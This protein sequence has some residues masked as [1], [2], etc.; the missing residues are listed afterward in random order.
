[1]SGV[2]KASELSIRTKISVQSKPEQ[3]QQKAK[4]SDTKSSEDSVVSDI[5]GKLSDT[6]VSGFVSKL[7][8]KIASEP[9]KAVAA[10]ANQQEERVEQ[11]TA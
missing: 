8:T 7:A 6:E 3:N 4:E 2:V 11:L 10:Q 5:K 9:Y 1:M